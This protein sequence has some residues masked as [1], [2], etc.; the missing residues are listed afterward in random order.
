M[1]TIITPRCLES[2]LKKGTFLFC[3]FFFFL[4]C[5]KFSSWRTGR[6]G[7]GWSSTETAFYK[8]KARVIHFGR[9][10]ACPPTLTG[11]RCNF[12]VSGVRKAFFFFF[13]FLFL[14]RSFALVTQAG[15][16]WRDLGSPQPPPPGFRQFSCLSLLST[17][18]YRHAPPQPANF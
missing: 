11:S 8:P 10:Y 6:S 17:W 9:V 18:D 16:Q 3:F 4:I 13:S 5:S 12:G 2:I 15:V 7:P 1:V 14:R